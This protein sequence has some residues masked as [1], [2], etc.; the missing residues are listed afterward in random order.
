MK[1]PY[2]KPRVVY[3]EKVEARATAC[4]KSD[5]ATPACSAGPIQS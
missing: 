1:H 5:P 3:A 4:A 2:E